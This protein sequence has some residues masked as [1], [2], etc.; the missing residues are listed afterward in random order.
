MGSDSGRGV[1]RRDG[2][3]GC[4]TE[5][6]RDRAEV[7][8]SA[9]VLCVVPSMNVGARQKATKEEE[10]KER[11]KRTHGSGGLLYIDRWPWSVGLIM[12]RWRTH[13][14]QSFQA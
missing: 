7:G 6:G 14:W 2:I 11:K 1:R 9:R 4:A 5:A 13:V 10:R 12:I 8:F 3:Y